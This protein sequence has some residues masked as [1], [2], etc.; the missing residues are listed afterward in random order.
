MLVHVLFFFKTTE[1][2]RTL[3]GLV[4]AN[5]TRP[6]RCYEDTFSSSIISTLKKTNPVSR[7]L[8]PLTASIQCG[9]VCA[10]LLGASLTRQP[11]EGK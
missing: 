6:R 5:A 11:D 8:P 1:S 10:I 9:H 7:S 3:L 4:F 2:E